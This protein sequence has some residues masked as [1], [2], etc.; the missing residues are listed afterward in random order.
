L[1][2]KGARTLRKEMKVVLTNLDRRWLAAAD[3]RICDHLIEVLDNQLAG[4]A[5]HILGW[6]SFFPGE[7][8]L[9]PVFLARFG[10]SQIYLPRTLP[11]MTME[12]ISIGPNWEEQMK[13]GVF[14]IPEPIP[15]SGQVYDS[16]WAANTVVLVPGLAFDSSGNRVGRGGGC[17][18][19]FLGRTK[20]RHATKI[21]ICFSLQMIDQ[22][23]AESHDIAMDWICHERDLRKSGAHFEDDLP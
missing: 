12:F 7:I 17:Y 11:D 23:S 1:S 3:G 6:F 9:T 4:Q 8:N 20:M 10:K 15:G 5:A 14:G 21:G 18:D 19:R 2:R 13:P 22:V 16:A